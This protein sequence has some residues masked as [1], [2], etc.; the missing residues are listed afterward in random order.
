MIDTELFRTAYVPNWFE[1]LE[2]LSRM[3]LLESWRFK[4]VDEMRKNIRTPI[5]EKYIHA[6]Y[7]AQVLDHH[8]AVDPGEKDLAFLVRNEYAVFNTGLVSRY[9]KPIYGYLER[10]KREG[11]MYD[12]CFRGFM[13]DSMAPLKYINPLPI[14]PFITLQQGITP[15][16]SHLPIRVNVEHILSDTENVMR[17]PDWCRKHKNLSLLLEAAVEL[18]RRM[19]EVMPSVVVPQVYQGRIQYLMPIALTD[20]AWPDLAMAMTP[21][22]GYYLGATCLTLEMAYTNARL[23]ATPTASWLVQ[24]VE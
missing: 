21:M 19:T 13:D 18:T 4:I 5:L 15:Y 16:L 11:G 6:V 14:R 2:H 17:L 22:D 12:W 10:N 1:H 8:N 3:A 20:P 9:Y 7:K 23:L 24:L